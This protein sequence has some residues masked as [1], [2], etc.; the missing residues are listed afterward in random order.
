MKKIIIILFLLSA[1]TQYKAKNNND[2]SNIKFS[3]NLS[4]KQFKD[5]LEEYTINSPFPNIDN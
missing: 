5:K 1:C 4:F 2:L 3:D